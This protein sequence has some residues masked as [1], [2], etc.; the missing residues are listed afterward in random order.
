M[1]FLWKWV[2]ELVG[3]GLDWYVIL[4]LLFYASASL[5]PLALPLAVLLS[6][7]MTFGNLAEN[8]ELMA[9]KSAGVSLLKVMRPLILFIVL[10]SIGAFYF[11]NT[12]LPEAKLQFYSLL[13]DVRKQKPTLDIQEGIFYNKLEKYSIRIGEKNEDS[14]IIK[15]ILIY[16]HSG[17]NDDHVVI[18]AKKGR[19]VTTPGEQWLI[20]EL[21]DGVRY[22]E[23]TASRKKDQNFPYTRLQFEDYKMRF[24]LSAFKLHRS[25]KSLFK[26]HY[27]VFNIGQLSHH[28]DSL[29]G[30]LSEKRE[31]MREYLEP[32]FY[33]LRDSV[34][35][36]K[37]T[38]DLALEERDLIRNFP[39]K[40]RKGILK[41]ATNFARSVKGVLDVHSNVVERYKRMITT[42]HVEW[43][44]KFT[45]SA[46][47]LLLFLIGA[48]LG[49]IIRK[50]GLGMPAVASVLLFI[51]FHVINITGEKFAEG[52]FL[53]PF[54]GMWIPFIV[55]TPV[56]ILLIYL[57]NS[58][59]VIFTKEAYLNLGN[60]F[61]SIFSK[62]HQTYNEDPASN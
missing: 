51:V 36:Q 7:L 46:A 13:W 24:S 43:H 4:E 53:S 5:V 33:F 29:S 6:S 45:L 52:G 56:S 3:K 47:C 44:R 32:Y 9:F 39:E 31:K 30:K 1:Q 26:D 10:V 20:L 57:A 35:F 27:K 23:L 54:M 55:L 21:E 61:L 34:F 42:Y 62:K 15:D 28:S 8:Y 58:D 59:S 50:G 38:Y 16:D 12:V 25:D 22:K 37:K 49:A 60:Q 11:S 48:P 2:D 41:R 18:K 19:M 17:K 40:E 14:S